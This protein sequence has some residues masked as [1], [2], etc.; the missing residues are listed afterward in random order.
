MLVS[1]L[2][3]NR[4]E[5]AVEESHLE[6]S[7]GREDVFWRGITQKGPD[8]I[9]TV[10]TPATRSAMA[11]VRNIPIVFTMVLD[12]LI[13]LN[14]PARNS[15]VCGVTLAIPVEKQLEMMRMALPDIR[16]VGFI[17][18]RGSA[19]M[20]QS[21]KDIANREGLR[22]LA[23]EIAS[24]RDIP[25]ILRRILPEIDVLWMPPDAVIYERNILRFILLECFQNNVPI[26][27]ASRQIAI[28]G[29]P[30]ALGVDYEDIG[31]QTAELALRRLSGRT[32]SRSGIQHPRKVVLYINERVVSKLGINIPQNIVDQAITLQSGSH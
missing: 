23:S 11:H 30:L 26:M 19:Q 29:T 3:G 12:N 27:A 2:E 5:L 8:L 18:S 1:A 24:E 28:A 10:G 15:D 4:L 21:A 9:I 25:E 7:Q 13:D 32:F 6:N 20:Y 31:R 16:R 22:L 17:Y 14:S